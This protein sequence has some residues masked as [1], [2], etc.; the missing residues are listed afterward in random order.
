MVSGVR[1]RFLLKIAKAF[2]DSERGLINRL[3]WGKTWG[4]KRNKKWSIPGVLL[5]LCGVESGIH[6]RN[7]APSSNRLNANSN[8]CKFAMS[9][10]TVPVNRL[11]P[12]SSWI[13][14]RK[15]LKKQSG[16]DP[17][18]SCLEQVLELSE[19]ADG[20][21]QG[22]Q[23][24][25]ESHRDGWAKRFSSVLLLSISM[26]FSRGVALLIKSLRIIPSPWEST[27]GISMDTM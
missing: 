23:E 2:V 15:S 3:F 17:V 12:I 5:R 7:H 1:T 19:L 6:N 26:A 9:L 21:R 4:K 25:I 11:L 13:K 8:N 27:M 22:A 20:F 10:E 18:R 14:S 24:G 16:N